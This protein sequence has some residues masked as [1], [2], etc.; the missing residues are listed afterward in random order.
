MSAAI[1]IPGRDGRSSSHSD[2]LGSASPTNS[3]LAKSCPIPIPFGG[4]GGPA[5]SSRGDP[6]G[7]GGRHVRLA[8]K[9]ESARAARLRHK[10]YVSELHEQ[11][12]LLNARVRELER[13]GSH[14]DEESM[15]RTLALMKATLSR[16]QA[17]QLGEWLKQAA[18]VNEH[19]DLASAFEHCGLGDE[20][21]RGGAE[22]RSLVGA[23]AANGK[24]LAGALSGLASSLP[25]GLGLGGSPSLSTHFGSLNDSA[26]GP[27]RGHRQTSTPI[28]I[29]GRV[30]ASSL[31]V[32][33]GGDEQG[34]GFPMESDDEA[35]Q[36]L[37]HSLGRHSLGHHSLGGAAA[38]SYSGGHV[39]SLGASPFPL[40][41]GG[42][43]SRSWDDIESA[44]AILSL[45]DVSPPH[46]NSYN[47]QSM[48]LQFQ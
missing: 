33:R 40:A 17:A 13:S 25:S 8:R 4:L 35:G 5:S 22:L 3:E 29:G 14:A 11:M 26:G 41:G 27:M 15:R 16:E 47:V 48:D 34:L 31:R 20:N 38:G 7:S 39:G 10:Q 1:A 18:P 21:T 23:A 9:A 2:H 19:C 42:A 28:A 43:I 6:E 46:G 44:Q 37:G 32:S 36:S 45:H 24:A 12:L 30:R